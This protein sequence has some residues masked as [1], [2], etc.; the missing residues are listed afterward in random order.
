MSNFDVGEF[1]I[2]RPLA[3]HLPTPL[4]KRGGQ[5]GCRGQ[6]APQ[7]SGKRRNQPCGKLEPIGIKAMS[8]A[9]EEDC[10]K[11]RIGEKNLQTRTGSG[12]PV[13]YRAEISCKTGPKGNRSLAVSNGVVGFGLAH[14]RFRYLRLKG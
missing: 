6:P 10:V 13:E 9:V 12:I 3:L 4:S 7:K 2:C 11:T 14:F 1:F 8:Q 5:V